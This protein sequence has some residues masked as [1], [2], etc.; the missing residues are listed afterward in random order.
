MTT[1]VT[2]PDGETVF[3]AVTP[4]VDLLALSTLIHKLPAPLPPPRKKRSDAG[5]SK[6]KTEAQLP[7]T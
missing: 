3:L 2:N 4:T 7:L 6:K 5:V 1:T